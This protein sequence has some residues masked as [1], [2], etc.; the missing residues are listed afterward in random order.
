MEDILDEH[1][2]TDFEQSA[3]KY[4]DEKA[5]SGQ[6]SK[7][8]PSNK[9][10]KSKDKNKNVNVDSSGNDNNGGQAQQIDL[11]GFDDLLSGGNK[12]ILLM[13][14]NKIAPISCNH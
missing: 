5:K 4:R 3:Q 13:N 14:I 9:A 7:P 8:K 1:E 11:L 12:M 2:L 6:L 10:R